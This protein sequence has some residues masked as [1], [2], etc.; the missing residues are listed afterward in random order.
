MDQRPIGIFDS[1]LGGLTAVREL[2]K[3]LPHEHIV[4]FG[5]NARVPYGSRSR[6]TIQRY[7]EQNIRFLLSQNVKFI[8]AACGTVSTNPPSDRFLQQ[9]P[10]EYSNVLLPAVRSACEKTKNGK[11]GIIATAASIH[12][13]AYEREIR[14]INPAFQSFGVACPLFVPLIE[15]GYIQRDNEVTLRVA[16]DYLEPLLAQG[17][18]TL[19]LGC[20]HYPIIK[21][22]LSD[23]VGTPVT[24][25][26]S[27]KECARHIKR[28]LIEHNL[29]NDSEQPGTQRFFVSDK[30]RGFK[31][32]AS[33][34]LG[35]DI[36]TR[37]E[38]IAIDTF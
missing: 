15:N 2:K 32:N 9:L 25:V 18:D 33:L 35:E 24:M 13:G 19:I 21:G 28:Y 12:S 20:T 38:Q 8:A 10:V 22:L 14:N 3:L 5:D 34:F 26:D 1:G 6:E 23:I 16:R 37:V 31:E 29:L 4:Y 11:I 27:G 36:T 7:A 17:I 30:G